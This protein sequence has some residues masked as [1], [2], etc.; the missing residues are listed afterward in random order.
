MGIKTV[1]MVEKT[2]DVLLHGHLYYPGDIKDSNV[3][4]VYMSNCISAKEKIAL[5]AV[6]TVKRGWN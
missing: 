4:R 1:S 5:F 2:N 3:T 6:D